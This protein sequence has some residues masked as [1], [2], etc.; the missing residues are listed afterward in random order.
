M[1]TILLISQNLSIIYFWRIFGPSHSKKI[2]QWIDSSCGWQSE[3]GCPRPWPCTPSF[4]HCPLLRL[5]LAHKP[6]FVQQDLTCDLETAII[7]PLRS[8]IEKICDVEM[9]RKTSLF[10]LLTIVAFLSLWVAIL[11]MSMKHID[12]S[13]FWCCL[14]GTITWPKNPDEYYSFYKLLFLPSCRLGHN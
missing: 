2:S 3:Q 7:L 8:F 14:K 1:P 5:L 12:Y 11:F 9:M 10:L 13:T 4:L 6:P